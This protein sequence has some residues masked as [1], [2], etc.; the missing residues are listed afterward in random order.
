M[1]VKK[2]INP[3][4]INPLK[5]TRKRKPA[6]VHCATQRLNAENYIF[7]YLVGLIEGDGW[8]SFSKNDK[9]LI[10]EMGIELHVRDLTLLHTVQNLLGGIGN[11]NV[12]KNNTKCRFNIRNKSHLLHTV[13]PV[14][15]KYPMF[16]NKNQIY[17]K[18]RYLLYI[19]CIHYK[20]VKRHFESQNFKR[21]LTAFNKKQAEQHQQLKIRNWPAY[22]DSW[23]VGFIE[24]EACFSVYPLKKAHNAYLVVSFDI[25][26]T[27]A[28][29]LIT[30]IKYFLKLKTK[31]TSKSNGYYQLKVSSV[32]CIEKIVTFLESSKVHLLGYK[33]HQYKMWLKQLN[34]IQ[35][36]KHIPIEAGD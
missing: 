3:L 33:K 9:Y 18:F 27:N 22:F 20:D 23:L 36:Y 5:L 15:D 25:G 6:V 21:S 32:E 10:Y 2:S 11:I 14:F 17:F 7:A 12:Y 35:R 13:L 19:N 8:F 24:A 16:S 34:K 26:Q 1:T 30:A 28:E 29:S 31:I 4:S